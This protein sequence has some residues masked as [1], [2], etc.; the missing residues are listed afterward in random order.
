MGATAPLNGS[1]NLSVLFARDI[2]KPHEIRRRLA[3]MP[4][5]SDKRKGG[6]LLS[7][8]FALFYQGG[9]RETSSG[10]YQPVRPRGWIPVIPPTK[11]NMS[12][13]IGTK[14]PVNDLI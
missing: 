9:D 13:S 3:H 8:A 12:G 7:S 11:I 6:R 14:K 5:A 2:T 4:A 1:I 10:A